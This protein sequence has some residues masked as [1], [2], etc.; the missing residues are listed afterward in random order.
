M[1]SA[2][3]VLLPLVALCLSACGQV[4]GP[5][6]RERELSYLRCVMPD[7]LL[8][9]AHVE[10]PAVEN[11]AIQSA[12]ADEHLGLHLFAGQKK[13]NGG[14]RAEISIDYPH[15]PGDTVH[16][17]WRFMVPK[18]FQSDAPQNRWWIIG[19]WHDQPNRDRG[20][21]WDGFPSRSPP[22]LLGSGELNDQ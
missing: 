13:L 16:Y 17:A 9:F 14:I 3:Y 22:V 12:G 19:Q 5:D 20:E 4:A 1:K 6:A 10:V 21:N 18:G 7:S 11:V 15:Q 2:S 8:E